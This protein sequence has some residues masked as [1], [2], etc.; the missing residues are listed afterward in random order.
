MN[1]L[2]IISVIVT[3]TS[4]VTLSVVWQRGIENVNKADLRAFRAENERQ[5]ME[6]TMRTVIANLEGEIQRQ[7][8]AKVEELDNTAAWLNEQITVVTMRNRMAEKQFSEGIG[9]VN[10]ANGENVRLHGIKKDAEKLL[11][12]SKKE[13][14]EVREASLYLY[15]HYK[16]LVEVLNG[17]VMDG[18]DY[19][20]AVALLSTANS[21]L[22]IIRDNFA[23]HFRKTPEDYVNQRDNISGKNPSGSNFISKFSKN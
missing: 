17:I 11:V 19:E 4:L 5:D 21:N 8:F 3:V 10:W 1:A 15:N 12:N 16:V 7:I 18:V 20:Q 13:L 14:Y 9:M 6:N 23:N 2:I 22:M